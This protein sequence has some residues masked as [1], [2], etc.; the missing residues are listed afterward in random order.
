[1]GRT[2]NYIDVYEDDGVKTM[3]LNGRP[4]ETHPFDSDYI[5]NL[6]KSLISE[7]SDIEDFLVLGIKKSA[8]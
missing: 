1:M 7:E 2:N 5:R 6:R 3:E 8:E 4:I